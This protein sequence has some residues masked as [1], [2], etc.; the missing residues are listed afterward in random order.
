MANPEFILAAVILFL[1]GSAM[2]LAPRS[3]AWLSMQYANHWYGRSYRRPE[4]AIPKHRM[5][6]YGL[7]VLSTGVLWAVYGVLLANGL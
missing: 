1:V 7:L 2:V 5:R 3:A 6:W 4:D